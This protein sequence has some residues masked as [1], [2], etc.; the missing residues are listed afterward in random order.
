VLLLS[1]PLDAPKQS[2]Y[3]KDKLEIACPYFLLKVCEMK[4]GKCKHWGDGTGTGYPYDAGHMNY[5][6]NPQI[7]GN[8]HPSYG[9]GGERKTMLYAGG[10]KQDIMTRISFGCILFEP[11]YVKVVA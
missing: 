9:V 1:K 3:N 5:C 11:I 8:Q 2:T 10:E 7:H 6:K 4:C